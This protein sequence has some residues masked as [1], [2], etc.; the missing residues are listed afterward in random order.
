M[1]ETDNNLR[2]FLLLIHKTGSISQTAEQCHF[3]QSYISKVIKNFEVEFGTPLINRNKHPLTL[4]FAGYECL[5]NLKR[6]QELQVNLRQQMRLLSEE[7]LHLLTICCDP[8]VGHGWYSQILKQFYLLHPHVTVKAIQLNY[9]DAVQ[10]AQSNSVDVVLDTEVHNER[11]AYQS[12]GIVPI[13]FLIP[14]KSAVY[15]AG[16]LWRSFDTLTLSQLSN[17]PLITTNSKASSQILFDQFLER[18][19]V[20]MNHILE[21]NNNQTATELALGQVAISYCS[22]TILKAIPHDRLQDINI[23]E[24][25]LSKL[26]YNFGINIRK[27]LSKIPEVDDLILTVQQTFRKLL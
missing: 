22:P 14:K 9:K 12:L 20:V 19:N 6:Q 7:H 10:L 21:V 23:V 24:V 27:E 16:V 5:E 8:S 17:Q 3:S 4:T 18:N 15:Q 11:F 13:Y 25:P 2:Q 26:T 1:N